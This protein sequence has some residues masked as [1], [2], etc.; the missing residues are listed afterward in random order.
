MTSTTGS[1]FGYKKYGVIWVALIALLVVSTFFS[2]LP[3][4]KTRIIELIML[5][6]LIKFS[7]VAWYYMHLQGETSRPLWVVVLFPFFLIALAAALILI[8]PAIFS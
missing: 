5:V 7:L 4:S 2:R 6:S 8:G 3:I 1:A